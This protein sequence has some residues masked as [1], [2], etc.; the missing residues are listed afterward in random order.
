MFVNRKVIS[1]AY[2]LVRKALVV[3]VFFGGLRHCMNL[4]FVRFSSIKDFNFNSCQ[5]SVSAASDDGAIPQQIIDFLA[6]KVY[7]CHLST[8]LQVK[9]PLT[10]WL[11]F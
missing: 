3:L 1:G 2:R 9:K 5:Y 8:F 10:A 6:G 7:Q 11:D 4:V